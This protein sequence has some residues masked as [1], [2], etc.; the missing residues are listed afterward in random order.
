MTG[1]KKNLNKSLAKTE[2]M[3]LVDKQSDKLSL[4]RQCELLDIARSSYYYKPSKETEQNL[5]LMQQ[6]D[7]LHL[8]YPFYGVKRM[9]AALSDIYQPLNEKRIRRL[10]HKMG[11]VTIYPKL[12]LSKPY[13]W[14][15]HFPYLLRNFSIERANQVWS[16]DI[17]YIPMEKGFMYMCAVIDWYSRYLIYWTI[18]NTLTSD[19]CIEAVEE[20]IRVNGKPEIINTD[21]GSQ[22]ASEQFIECVLSKGIQL[23]MDGKGRATDNIAIERFWRSL[24]YENIYLYE[25]KD[26]VELYLGIAGYV[27]FYN[28][29]RKHQS[30]EEQTPENVYNTAIKKQ[31][32]AA[33]FTT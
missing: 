29:E 15:Q 11:I 12:N 26:S 27:D 25:Y 9:R 19:F 30:L 28:K 13:K 7:K 20:G 4:K 1:L 17:T 8:K 2:K 22:F 23:S 24:K 21:Q 32:T 14:N 16:T 5:L 18:S 10:M 31:I 3:K 6:I 33:A